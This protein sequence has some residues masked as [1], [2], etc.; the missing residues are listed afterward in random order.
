MTH[1]DLI[2][3]IDNKTD[4]WIINNN[5]IKFINHQRYYFIS[6]NRNA[7]KNRKQYQYDTIQYADVLKV[8]IKIK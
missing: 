5:L 7:S 8:F 2:R 4:F 1:C 6:H 3:F